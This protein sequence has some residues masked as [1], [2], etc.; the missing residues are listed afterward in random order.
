MKTNKIA[1]VSHDSRKTEMLEWVKFNA[2]ELSKHKLYATGTTG[3]YVSLLFKTL[4]DEIAEKAK[5]GP[6]YAEEE[7]LMKR[8]YDAADNITLLLSG[9]LGGDAQIAVMAALDE[10]DHV[11]FFCDT[12]T[13][14]GHNADIQGLT[15]IA[16][17]Y[18]IGFAMN[19]TTA[20]MILTSPLFNDENYH[21][22][23]P[24]YIDEYKNR[25]LNV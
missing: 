22:I 19:R 10:V 24:R 16:I 11:I 23:L 9:P 18:N 15:R 14:Q 7:E 3:K 4:G 13:M 12:L 2:N 5:E 21:R 8:Y 6:L 25:K 20:D 17:T 1:L